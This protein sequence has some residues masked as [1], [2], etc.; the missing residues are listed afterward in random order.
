MQKRF[1]VDLQDVCRAV[2]IVDNHSGS[3]SAPV[4]NTTTKGVVDSSFPYKW[5]QFQ[6][7]AL[8]AEPKLFDR[9]FKRNTEDLAR[10]IQM[11]QDTVDVGSRLLSA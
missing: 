9:Y 2:K 7:A 5:V 3:A 11:Y 10:R 4:V 1:E 6:L 8:L